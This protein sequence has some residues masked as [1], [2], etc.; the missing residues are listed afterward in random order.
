MRSKGFVFFWKVENVS[1]FMCKECAADAG[2]REVK[3]GALAQRVCLL[4]YI[5]LGLI[6]PPVWGGLVS[7]INAAVGGHLPC[8]RAVDGGLTT[9]H[10]GTRCLRRLLKASVCL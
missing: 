9:C 1:P 5:C 4:T 3:D 7:N 2:G 10:L 8:V 6:P